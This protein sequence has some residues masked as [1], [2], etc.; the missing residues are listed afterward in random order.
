MPN[1]IDKDNA[2]NEI[3]EAYNRQNA[4]YIQ[5]HHVE[6]EGI[7]NGLKYAM[8]ILDEIPTVTDINRAEILRL[9]NEIEELAIHIGQQTM[10]DTVYAEAQ[11]IFDKVKAIGKELTGDAGTD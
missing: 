10:N 9:C 3:R 5:Y 8:S 2:I 7:A 11:M 4:I 6:R 1:L